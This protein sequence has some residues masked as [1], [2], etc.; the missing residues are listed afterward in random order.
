MQSKIRFKLL[1]KKDGITSRLLSMN[2]SYINVI[3]VLKLN[4]EF[5]ISSESLL[6][7]G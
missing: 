4:F 7:S 5:A 6:K 2:V 3:I 1:I